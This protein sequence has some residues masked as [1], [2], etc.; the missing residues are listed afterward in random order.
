L[1]HF[2]CSL[3][4]ALGVAGG[5]FAAPAQADNS[6]T[7]DDFLTSLDKLGLGNVD[8]TKAISAGPSLCPVLADRGQNTA[9]IASTVSDAIGKPLGPATEFTGT[10][11]SILCPKAV[12]NVTQNLTDGKP[13][14]PLFG[15]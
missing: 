8:L 13:L 7:I 14:I 10:A 2:S 12:E 4:L 1:R 6:T 11:I 3:L 9:D 5:V 15:N